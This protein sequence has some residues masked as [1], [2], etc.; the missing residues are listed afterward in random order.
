VSSPTP[1]YRAAIGGHPIVADIL[2]RR[3]YTTLEA[4][5]A[6]LDAHLYTP[7]PPSAWPGMAEAVARLS[8]A[9]QHGER[10]RVWGDFDADGQTST[11]LLLLGLRGLGA[12][13]DFTI[14]SRA[15]NHHSR[16]LH[17]AGL[18]Q[19]ADE[20][21][22]VIV[23]C[24]CGVTDYAEAAYARELGLDL[25]ITDHHDIGP[26]LP[27]ACAVINPKRLPAD[28]PAAHLPGAGVAYVLVEGLSHALHDSS[29][30]PAT[31]LDLAALGIVADVAQQRGDTRYL[32][33]RGL[34]QLRAAPRPGVR[35]L[36]RVANTD[37]ADVSA[38]TIGYQ[39]G[40]R[41]NAVGRLD[42][43]ALCVELLTTADEAR[44]HALA[45][46]VETLNQERKVLQRAIEDEAFQQIARNPDLLK[47]EVIVLESPAWHPSVLGVVASAV[48]NRYGKPVVLITA[49]PDEGEVGRGSARS[50][51]GV[52][53]HAAIVAQGDLVETSGGHPMA[54]GFAIRA[55]NVPAFRAGI[56]RT[57]AL[58]GQTSTVAEEPPEATL[59]WRDVTLELCA[60]LERLAPFGPG[61]PRP[62]L[63]STGL[64][65]VRVEP[66]GSEGRHQ[67]LFL[68]DAQGHAIRTLWWR[69]GGVQ[70]PDPCDLVYTLHTDH[71][72]G[73]ARMQV[74]IVRIE[75]VSDSPVAAAAP[76]ISGLYMIIDKR[77]SRVREAELNALF[78]ANGAAHVQVWAE[79]LSQPPHARTRLQLDA[80]SVLIIYSPPPGMDELQAALQR[81]MPQ[82]VVLLTPAPPHALPNAE[83]A[84]AALAHIIDM[85]QS[86]AAQG[87]AMDDPAHITRVAAYSGER[88]AT[89]RAA[90]AYSRA[91]QAGDRAAAQ[92]AWQRFTYFLNETRAY[93]LFFHDVAAET[94]L[95]VSS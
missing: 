10:V 76:R 80:R 25:I 30:D 44:A 24:D 59:D 17:E 57:V 13:V 60:D 58:L 72:H 36:L 21:V 65:V 85:L 87:D 11:S 56:S 4:A 86:R 9:I 39:I 23:T 63:R 70:P 75:P 84:E 62:L 34:A 90:A 52:D 15:H 93:H 16:G 38:D 47:D 31:L 6:F 12:Q 51:R 91:Q 82:T 3:G 88:E 37:P 54:A 41:L 5:R 45:A 67:A 83:Q 22:R 18:R 42:D 48:S 71:F 33:Q 32:L 95:R 19:A 2:W 94:L 89:V 64:S 77:G 55:E 14:P 49:K 8:A 81:A 69:S 78:A 26:E 29:F 7:T 1:E 20:G 68:Q 40:P 27:A 50:V 79:G 66:L 46:R 61:N 28:H 53:I 92:R 35:A 73:K 43:A 74:Q